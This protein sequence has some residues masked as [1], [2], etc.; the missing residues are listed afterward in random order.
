MENQLNKNIKLSKKL[1][2][3]SYKIK[4]EYEN[5][6][7]PI[8]KYE[9]L[10][11]ILKKPKI[12]LSAEDI[13]IVKNYLCSKV[14]YIRNLSNE[15]DKDSL[16]KI[17]ANMNFYSSDSNKRIYN[18]GDE[19]DKFYIILKGSVGMY[20]PFPKE[21]SFTLHEYIDYLVNVRDVENNQSKF[22]R[23][24][25][26]NSKV[27]KL[28]LVSLNYD[29]SQFPETEKE[30]FIIEDER[31]LNIVYPG[32]IF[33]ETD[34]IKNE[35]R[36]SSVI[37]LEECDLL[38]IDKNDCSKIKDIEEQR[39][40]NI[41]GEFRKDFPIFKYWNNTKCFKLISGL[42]TENYNKGEC[43]CKQNEIPKYIYFVKEGILEVFTEY[44]FSWY[45]NFI[46][47]IYDSSSSLINDLDSHI[48]WKEDRIHKKIH[49]TYEQMKSPFIFKK[50]KLDHITLSF[51]ENDNNDEDNNY[52]F[53]NNLNEEE[54]KKIKLVNELEKNEE[55]AK[56]STYK[57]NIQK[58]Y[59][60]QMFGYLEALEL[61]RRFC[62]IKCFS[63]NALILKFPFIEFLQL[64]P[65][66][67]TNQFY[68]QKRIFEEKKNLIEQ[69]KNNVL[70]KLNFIKM[71]GNKNKIMKIIGTKKLAKGSQNQFRCTKYSRNIN[72]RTLY[73]EGIFGNF[74]NYKKYTQLK[75]LKYD[76][77]DKNIFNK[78]NGLITP[79]FKST[80]MN[81]NKKNFEAIKNLY[82]H[83]T[84]NKYQEK[85]IK[86]N[87]RNF[88]HINESHLKYFSRNNS[89]IKIPYKLSSSISMS[90]LTAK[91]YYNFQSNKIF[92]EKLMK[93]KY[94]VSSRNN[95]SLLPNINF[96]SSGDFQKIKI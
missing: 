20:K 82:P 72:N 77:E 65:T 71:N 5:N 69:L 37:T 55:K 27:S 96:K 11:D 75:E 25:D 29:S 81:L 40:N 2:I 52:N 31:E 57:A 13:S 63:S 12:D 80:M 43:I 24:Q 61:K 51:N 17:I 91:N 35:T 28:K 38:S 16:L 7:E 32:D 90:D 76:L 78:T 84:K 1:I 30:S 34:I 89:Y 67:K 56:N 36:N 21:I 92:F 95:K 41:L 73:G 23:I 48:L 74:E 6:N 64:L 58:L 44:N 93:K 47:Y 14:K 70:A 45:E 10:I 19:S 42:I 46:E 68:L 83:T 33:G 26:Y 60:P 49:R 66:D 85:I 50:A 3:N 18:Y 87:K 59:S 8:I 79:N 22:N 94:K 15:I 86:P 9:D 39:I 53:N 4:D 54:N 88:S 62:T